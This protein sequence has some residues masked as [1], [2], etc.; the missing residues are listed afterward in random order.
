MNPPM[1]RSTCPAPMA[2]DQTNG[3]V[4]AENFLVDLGG[5]LSILSESIYT[6]GPEVFIR[7]LLQ[8]GQDAITA[9]LLVEPDFAGSM[10]VEVVGDADGGVTVIVEDNGIGLTLEESRRALATIAFSMKKSVAASS[11]DSPFVGRFGIGILS[12]FLVADEITIFSRRA[13]SNAEPVQWVGNIGGTFVTRPANSLSQPGTRV[14]LRLR[15]DA[16]RDFGADEIFAVAQ[17]YGRYLQHPITF[18]GGERVALVNDE[19]PL[20]EQPLNQGEQLEA[21]REIFDENL[22]SVFHFHSEEAGARGLAFIKAESCHA[23]AE[24]THVIFIK[25]MLVS[26][27]ALDLEPAGAPFLSILM[28]SDR[29]RPNAGRDAVMA[30]DHRLP[31]LRRD[32]EKALIAHLDTLHREDPERLAA[33]V[34]TQYRCLAHL[35]SSNRAYLRFLL[36]HLPMDTTLGEMS[37][38]KLFRRHSSV[39]EYVTDGTDFQRLQGK[40]CSEGD[41]IVRV[42]TEAAHRLIELVGQNSN[43]AKAKRITSSEYLGRFTQTSMSPSERETAM[44]HELAAELVKENCTGVF[45]ETED[46]DEI[47]RLDMGTEESLDRLLDFDHDTAG[48]KNLLLNRLHPVISQMISGAAATPQLRAWLRLLYHTAL[49]QAREVP[50]AA[51]SRR[52]SHSLSNLFTSSTLGPL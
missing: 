46:Q 38:G 16:A 42:E 15:A 25:H 39:V 52:F 49:L 29:L 17:K 34:M 47:A 22:L 21:G 23:G 40:A 14:F 12:G 51:E 1:T 3:S 48:A 11:D 28:N 36:D 7:E 2:G 6:A 8:N 32:I 37:L 20:W 41:C 30:N 50:T 24:A 44:L 33:I 45:F 4:R 27:R 9:R 5:V 10:S 43:G 18:R 26:E 13:G 19:K 31:A 35:A